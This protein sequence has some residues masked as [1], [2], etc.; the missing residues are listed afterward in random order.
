MR[1][2]TA[3][4][5]LITAAALPAAAENCAQLVDNAW[6]KAMNANDLDGIAKL[7][8]KDAIGWF[9]NMPE[10]RGAD[11]IRATYKGLLDA[12]TVKSAKL[13]E[14]V[15]KEAGKQHL[16]WGKFA[17]TL[18]PKAG[19]AEQVMAGRYSEVAEKHGK[20]CV[21]VIDHA[22]A[23]PPKEAPKAAAPAAPAPAAK[24]APKDAPKK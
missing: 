15:Y 4:L 7:Y 18:Q 23:E 22:S 6:M 11:A 1:I 19:G 16:S 20:D 2:R 13:T 12:N 24:P 17:I 8:A 5:A 10:A 9:P 3:V 14:A 21:F